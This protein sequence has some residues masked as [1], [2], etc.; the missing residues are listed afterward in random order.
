LLRRCV[1]PC[2][3]LWGGCLAL[4]ERTK[5]FCP[6]ENPSINYHHRQLPPHKPRSSQAASPP[7]VSP[8]RPPFHSTHQHHNASHPR[9]QRTSAP[10]VPVVTLRR[11]TPQPRSSPTPACAWF[12]SCACVC[13]CTV[14]IR[15]R[16]GQPPLADVPALR[17]SGSGALRAVPHPASGRG[18]LGEGW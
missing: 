17:A 11:R 14:G 3:R 10:R 16:S 4:S 7:T 18:V 12:C 2:R 15:W 8:L 5:I 6:L 9:S 1:P 13:C